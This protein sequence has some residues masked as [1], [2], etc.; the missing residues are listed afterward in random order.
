MEQLKANQGFS[1]PALL[2]LLLALGLMG[3]TAV[4]S[5]QMKARRG[6]DKQ[7]EA[8]GTHFV[9]ALAMYRLAIPDD[10]SL[11]T[12]IEQ[13][14]NDTRGRPQRH[15]RREPPSPI[16]GASWQAIRQPDGSINGIFLVSDR[17][18]ARRKYTTP[19]G[20]AVDIKTYRDWQFMVPEM[21][22]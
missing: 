8:T 19:D 11:P 1:Y 21:P 10:P 22:Q 14:L 5:A 3:Q 18:P 7:I 6:L 13:L 20:Q 4:Y 15:L 16:E 17:I 9:H 2:G 12:N